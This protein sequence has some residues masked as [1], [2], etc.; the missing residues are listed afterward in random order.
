M[1]CLKCMQ[2]TITFVVT[3]TRY[4]EMTEINK[5]KN[6]TLSVPVCLLG[7]VGSASVS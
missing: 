2:D 6:C 4:S 3:I 5:Y 7:A 1:E